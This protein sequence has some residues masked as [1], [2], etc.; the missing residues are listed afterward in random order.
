MKY[1]IDPELE[2]ISKIKMPNNP[3]LLPFMN[4]AF[5]SLSVIP[6]VKMTTEGLVDVNLQKKMDMPPV[7]MK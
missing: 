3:K 7:L 2:L 1:N 5:V 4:M 6:F